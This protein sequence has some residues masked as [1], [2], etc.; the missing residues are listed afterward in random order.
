M[1]RCCWFWG[2]DFA[3]VMSEESPPVVD[4]DLLLGF[5]AGFGGVALFEFGGFGAGLSVAVFLQMK[6]GAAEASE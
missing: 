4:E 5:G 3:E 1:R 6:D 2:R